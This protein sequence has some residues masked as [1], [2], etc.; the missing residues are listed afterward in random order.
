MDTPGF[1]RPCIRRDHWRLAIDTLSIP[2]QFGDRPEA[3]I[4]KPKKSR[5]EFEAE[6]RREVLDL[7]YK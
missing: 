6:F 3:S 5:T 7:S 4:E 2:N 1:P